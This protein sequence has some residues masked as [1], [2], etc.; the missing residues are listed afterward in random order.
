MVA[1]IVFLQGSHASREFVLEAGKTIGIGRSRSN[2]IVVIEGDVSARH[3]LVTML[4]SGEVELEVLSSRTTKIADELIPIG[5]RRTLNPGEVVSMGEIVRFSLAVG[6]DVDAKTDFSQAEATRL[7]ISGEESAFATVTSQQKTVIEPLK[8]SA[9]AV[10]IEKNEKPVDVNATV[11]METRIASPEEM[12]AIRAVHHKKRVRKSILTSI[13]I[14]AFIVLSVLLYVVYKPVKEE[15]ASWPKDASGDYRNAYRIIE[16]YLAVVYPD[17]AN[18]SVKKTQNGVVIETAIG[19]TED[20]PLRISAETNASIDEF[21]FGRNVS[22]DRFRERTRSADPSVSWG[23]DSRMFFIGTERGAGVP[24]NFV[25]Y[26]RR[27]GEEDYSGHLLYVRY[28]DRVT[29]IW[30]E[31]PLVHEWR[32]SRFMRSHTASMVIYATRLVDAH[33]EGGDSSFLTKGK[34]AKDDLEAADRYLK[35]ESSI[36][37][38]KAFV[39]LRNALV[40]A[41]LNKEEATVAAARD[42]LIALRHRQKEWYDAKCLAYQYARRLGDSRYAHEMLESIQSAC[43][44]VFT[45]ELQDSDCRYELIRRKDWK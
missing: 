35:Q 17:I 28:S 36:Y 38:G 34:T 29:A 9:K 30:I 10:A 15:Y 1:K 44:S 45:H 6:Q 21:Y 25:S 31:V 19:Q 18:A 16:P 42:S 22:F 12:E 37:W 13:P 39:A 23:N 3:L 14:I 32:A 11:V 26:T 8:S 33:W 24:V 43:E 40:K 20:V 41:S 5:T 4:S 7:E 27:L 2:E